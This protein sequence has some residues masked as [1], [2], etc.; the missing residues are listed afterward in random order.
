MNV[1]QQSEATAAR[2]RVYFRLVSTADGSDVTGATVTVRIAKNGT[3]AAGGGS[4]TEVD[5]SDQPGL[6]YYEA[7]TGDVDTLGTLI[8]TPS[9][10]GA[11]TF[12]Y[13][14]AIVEY[15]P[16]EAP[17]DADDVAG[18]VAA[19]LGTGSGLTSLASA[20]ALST[21]SSNLSGLISDVG[22]NGSGLTAIPWNSAW[23]AEVQSECADAL[24]AYDPPTKSELDAAVAPLATASGLSTV[25]GKIDTIDNIVDAILVDTDTTIPGLL[26]TIDGNVD[27]ILEDTGT[28]LP[29]TLST[30][31][32]NVDSI[33]TDTGT[34]IPGQ[35]SG[36]SFPTAGDIADA[37]WDEAQS[38]HESAGTFGA[39]LDSAVSGVSTGGV[40]A[41]DIADAVW[42]E[43]L[44]GHQNAGSAG[45]GLSSAGSGADAGTIATAVA[46][47]L[48][49]GSGFTAIT[50]ALS[51]IDS[52]VDAI[53]TDTG[54]TLDQKI[55]AIDNIV[56]AIKA[57]T[58]SLTF[59]NGSVDA[60]IAR[61]NDVAT[62]GA[63]TEESPWGPA[64]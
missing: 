64:A 11:Y 14:V 12:S 54:T 36:I 20:S 33:L 56:D 37:V 18:A 42:D 9:A 53:L 40:S 5:S 4:V 43:D 7:S 2:R 10:S 38:G 26:A 45:A 29:A 22:S 63:G 17:D 47:E 16:F 55:D 24:S 57:K 39:Y 41:A 13:P 6:Y 51:T 60:N 21:V 1:I 48:G 35:I 58:D 44:S 32:G 8:V 62:T 49:D 19:E 61:I 31:G 15:S 50:G 34:T 52:I 25:D 23:D 27:S 46:S 3:D 59:S 28:T 30:I